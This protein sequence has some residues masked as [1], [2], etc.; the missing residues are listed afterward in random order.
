MFFV[1]AM[2]KACFGG[3]CALLGITYL[4]VLFF[5]VLLG[6]FGSLMMFC[7]A[8][9][10]LLGRYIESTDLFFSMSLGSFGSL[11]LADRCI[12]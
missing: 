5:S 10:T 7:G 12:T 9:C 11:A 8:C 1:L 4:F 2:I 6:S 3:L